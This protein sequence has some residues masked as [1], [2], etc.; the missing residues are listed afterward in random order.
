M[1]WILSPVVV[2]IEF[3]TPEYSQPT[4]LARKISKLK[5]NPEAL[6]AFLPAIP[7]GI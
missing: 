7:T 6:F 4:E 1:L 5:T 3:D 2:C